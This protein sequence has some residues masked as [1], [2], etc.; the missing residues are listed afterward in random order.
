MDASYIERHFFYN[1]P[2]NSFFFSPLGFI[3]FFF[4]P[5]SFLSCCLLMVHRGSEALGVK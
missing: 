2:T 1:V 3:F 5:F 4:F